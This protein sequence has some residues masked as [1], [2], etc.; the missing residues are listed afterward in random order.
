MLTWCGVAALVSFAKLPRGARNM[1]KRFPAGDVEPEH[2]LLR[3]K[4]SLTTHPVLTRHVFDEAAHYELHKEG[5]GHR[6]RG[7]GPIYDG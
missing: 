1:R 5:P 4:K 6:H 2:I 3:T 7:L